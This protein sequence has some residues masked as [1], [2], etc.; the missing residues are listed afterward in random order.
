M[1]IY[2]IIFI[3]ND[4]NKA[5]VESFLNNEYCKNIF[6]EIKANP[7]PT[8]VEKKLVE[9]LRIAQERKVR[10][11][12]IG[13]LD[14]LAQAVGWTLLVAGLICHPLLIV[15]A[16][17]LSLVAAKKI[18]ELGEAVACLLHKNETSSIIPVEYK[19]ENKNR[20]EKFPPSLS[21]IG[22]KEDE[23]FKYLMAYDLSCVRNKKSFD[24]EKCYKALND[25]DPDKRQK[26]L[27]G[28]LEEYLEKES[29][30]KQLGCKSL[31]KL[32][33]L[34]LSR[35]DIDGF[36]SNNKAPTSSWMLPI[37]FFSTPKT[38]KESVSSDIFTKGMLMFQR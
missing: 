8:A 3:T 27:D 35:K 10:D 5:K 23:K 12:G 1:G 30:K 9:N 17:I 28:A 4:K 2:W 13:A 6:N 36:L 20:L 15:G 18:W 32:E 16:V 11:A 19:A 38:A 21:D 33:K 25:I 34:N 22:M 31:K 37:S 26:V 24:E 7:A 14:N 29:L